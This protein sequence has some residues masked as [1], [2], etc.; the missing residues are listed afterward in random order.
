MALRRSGCDSPWLHFL[1]S[2]AQDNPVY[3]PAMDSP[4][5]AQVVACIEEI[6]ER[7]VQ[8]TDMAFLLCDCGRAIGL[9]EALSLLELMDEETVRS[10]MAQISHLA[11]LVEMNVVAAE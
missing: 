7:S 11:A 8:A 2:P 5:P 9:I 6:L 1:S 3:F 4:D 10:Y